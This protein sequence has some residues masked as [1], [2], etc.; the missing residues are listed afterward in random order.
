MISSMN[1]PSPS[2]LTIRCPDDWHVH[3][4]DGAMLRAV[5]PHTAAQFARAIVMPNLVPPVTSV[6]AARAYR[7]RVRAAV[8]QH[9][10]FEPLMT[11][12][13]TDAADPHEI[14]RGHAEG[15]WTAAKLYPAHATTNAHFGVTSI[16]TIAPALDAMADI[17]MPLLVHGEVADPAVDIFDREAVFLERVLDRILRRHPGLKVVLEHVTTEQGVAFVRANAPR[18]AATVTPHHLVINRNAIF[19][20]GIRPHFYCLPVAKR[21]RHR[22]ALRAA[23][24]S[25][26]AGFFLGTDSAPHAVPLKENACGCAGI[27]NAPTAMQVYAQVFAEEGAL[28]RL[29]AFAALNGARFYGLPVNRTQL[30]LTRA[31]TSVDERIAVAGEAQAVAVFRG[32]E[33]LE[34]QVARDVVTSA[35][36][37]G[38]SAS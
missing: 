13:L 36:A 4:R 34:W 33:P 37:P 2:T 12:Y 30:S 19:A 17:G 11:C 38:A 5:V 8:P 14:V 32:G 20:G 25:G 1:L 16:D 21:E 31:G 28:D 15:V 27:F 9:T 24:T 10:T 23:A 22:L 7:E 3:F 6:D 26:E 29:E 18:L 35:P